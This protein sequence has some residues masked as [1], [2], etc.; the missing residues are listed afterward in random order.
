CFFWVV[1]R[2]MGVN[3]VRKQVIVWSIPTT[4]AWGIGLCEILLLNFIM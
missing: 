3:D 4:I 2:M 1:N